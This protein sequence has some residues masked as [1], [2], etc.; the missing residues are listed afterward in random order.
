MGSVR[1]SLEAKWQNLFR[2]LLQTISWH[3]HASWILGSQS[4]A[5]FPPE[6]SERPGAQLPVLEPV[7]S[8]V[9]GAHNRPHSWGVVGMTEIMDALCSAT[10]RASRTVRIE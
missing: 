8:V 5:P 9:R 3:S 2:Q 1:I 10:A 7:S 6:R 4:S